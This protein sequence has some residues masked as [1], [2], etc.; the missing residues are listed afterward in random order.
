M[1]V[2]FVSSGRS[3]TVGEVVKNQG[4]SLLR[5]GI[6]VDYFVIKPGVLGYISAIP[7]IR[8]IFKRGH[9]SLIHAHYSLSAISAALAGKMPL[10]V[11]LMGSDVYASPVS[12]SLLRYFY[13]YRWN[14]TIV[15][16]QGMKEV[17][18]FKKA[19][20][21]PNGVD[22]ERFRPINKNKAR[23][24][25]GYPLDKKLI[26]FVSNPVRME[27]NYEL[28]LR[29]VCLL[30]MKD[31]ELMPLFNLSNEAVTLYLNAADALLLTSRWEGSVNVI[32]EAMACNVPIVSTDV[33]D[34]RY[35]LEGVT[36]CYVCEG[37]QDEM[38]ARI[39]EV[40]QV[41]NRTN[42]RERLKLLELESNIVAQK[43]LKIYKDVLEGGQKF[44]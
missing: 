28:A 1:K 25:L 36:N 32:K 10:V 21:I 20:V 38:A 19:L 3:G 23:K 12:I 6:E 13:H 39:R 4:E 37:Q 29:A 5:A 27:K 11:S 17:L 35:N 33:G 16:T 30:N 22:L 24:Q 31:V 2:L 44:F 41:N 7:K 34:V 14:A 42:G 40:F 15:K 26:V 18:G 9:Y 8:K 43:I